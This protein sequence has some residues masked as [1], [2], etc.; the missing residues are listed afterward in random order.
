CSSLGMSVSCTIESTRRISLT[1]VNKNASDV[2]VVRNGPD[3]RTFRP[4]PVDL[5]LKDGKPHLLAYV[6]SM[7]AQDG[8]E[9]AIQALA[10]VAAERRDWHAVFAGDGDAVDDAQRLANELG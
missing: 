9:Y 8:V 7:N 1:R 2:F 4:G 5:R 6:G 3:P 10:V